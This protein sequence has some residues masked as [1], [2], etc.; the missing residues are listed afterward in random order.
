MEKATHVADIKNASR[1]S[2]SSSRT[3]RCQKGIQNNSYEIM[4]AREFEPRTLSNGP[5]KTRNG[6]DHS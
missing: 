2:A 6:Q 1:V 3:T 5:G 4:K